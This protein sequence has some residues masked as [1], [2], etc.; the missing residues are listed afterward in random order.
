MYEFTLIGEVPSKKNRW[1]IG[2]Q[3]QVY[4][5]QDVKDWVTSICWQLKPYL[6]RFQPLTGRVKLEAAFYI[7]RNKD[8]DNL[9]GS[10]MDGLQAAGI[11]ANDRLIME[12]VASKELVKKQPQVKVRLHVL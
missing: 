11:I 1:A 7:K 5:P 4:T 9:L 8:L 10:L 12:I 2:R 6:R 3:G